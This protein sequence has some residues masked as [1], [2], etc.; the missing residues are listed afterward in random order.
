[1]VAGRVVGLVSGWLGWVG[2]GTTQGGV[3]AVLLAGERHAG[4]AGCEKR[5]KEDR[6]QRGSWSHDAHLGVEE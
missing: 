6:V 4:Q 3:D 5:A 1:M 2:Q